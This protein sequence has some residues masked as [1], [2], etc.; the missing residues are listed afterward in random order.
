VSWTVK[1]VCAVFGGK[2]EHEV[3]G[4]YALT[5]AFAQV[6]SD[7]QVHYTLL[8]PLAKTDVMCLA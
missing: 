7:R 8:S 3:A 6:F 1:S 5:L 4:G 2:S